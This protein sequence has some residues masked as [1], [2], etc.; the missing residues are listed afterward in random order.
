MKKHLFHEKKSSEELEINFIRTQREIGRF[1]S[2]LSI[3]KI[4]TII[5]FTPLLDVPRPVPYIWDKT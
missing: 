5:D 4:N 2:S 3:S 1:F